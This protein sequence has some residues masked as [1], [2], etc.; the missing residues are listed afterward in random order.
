V[1][2]DHGSGGCGCY[3]ARGSQRTQHEGQ[4]TGNQAGDSRIVAVLPSVDDIHRRQHAAHAEEGQTR[5]HESERPGEQRRAAAQ[6]ADKTIGAHPRD[7]FALL[8]LALL[9]AALQT[10]Q[11]TD[12]QGDAELIKNLLFVIHWIICDFL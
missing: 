7:P 11:Q 6:E 5:D 1:N 8:R 3:L 4:Q 12:R 10:D 2:G 9:P